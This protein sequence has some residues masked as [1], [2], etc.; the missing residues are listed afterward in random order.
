MILNPLSVSNLND[1]QIEVIKEQSDKIKE[2]LE[3]MKYGED[4]SFEQFLQK[5]G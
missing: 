4:I 5:L 1:H 2:L 3:E